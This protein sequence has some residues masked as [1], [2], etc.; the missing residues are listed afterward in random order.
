MVDLAFAMAIICNICI[1]LRFLER[2]VWLSVVLSLITAAIQDML[3]I[4]TITPFL[5][6]FPRSEGYVYLQGFWAMAASMIFSVTA[7][8]LMFIDLVFTSH[9]RLR[10]SGVTRKQRILITE[11]MGMCLYLALGAL[12]FIYIEGW[13]YLDAL[14]FVF[15]TVTTIGFGD[16]VPTTAGG[17]VF[18]VFYAAGGI[19]FLGVIISSMRY[20]ILEAVERGFNNR[21][22]KRKAKRQARRMELRVQQAREAEDLRLKQ[23]NER[24]CRIQASDTDQ[25]LCSGEESLHGTRH[26]DSTLPHV[27]G[28]TFVGMQRTA[29]NPQESALISTSSPPMQG[30]NTTITF[31]DQEPPNRPDGGF[32]PWDAIDSNNSH[33]ETEKNHAVAS[34]PNDKSW[35]RR[36]IPFL[37][38]KPT[39]AELVANMHRAT[40]EELQKAEKRQAH[41]ET[42]REYRVRLLLSAV[43]FVAYWLIGGIVFSFLETWDFGTAIY[44][45][46][47]TFTT[48]GYGDLIPL[49][50]AGR[51]IFLVYGLFGI[52][53]L[54]S[55][56]SLIGEDLDKRVK[57]HE[58]DTQLTRNDLDLE[59]G[60][61]Q[62]AKGGDS[63]RNDRTQM[64]HSLVEASPDIDAGMATHNGDCE[65]CLQKLVNIANEF[66][67]LLQKVIAQN[68]SQIGNNKTSHPSMTL[69]EPPSHGIVPSPS[70]SPPPT[71]RS[72]SSPSYP[73]TRQHNRD[74]VIVVPAIQW[75]QLIDYATQFRA[76]T[77][78][79]E[80]AQQKVAAWDARERKLREKRHKDR[81]R[82]KKLLQKRRKQLEEQ[83]S[84]LESDS[85]NEKEELEDLKDWDEEGS[86]NDDDDEALDQSRG[87]IAEML[88]GKKKGDVRRSSGQCQRG[89]RRPSSVHHHHSFEQQSQHP[90]DGLDDESDQNRSMSTQPTRLRRS[91]SPRS[92]IESANHARADYHY[93][94]DS[95]GTDASVQQQRQQ[96]QIDNLRQTRPQSLHRGAGAGL[97]PPLARTAGAD[98]TDE[99]PISVSTQSLTQSRLLTADVIAHAEPDSN[100]SEHRGAGALELES[101]HFPAP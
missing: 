35:W 16:K 10:G 78:A 96:E 15:I 42:M 99:P 85:M 53:A 58:V 19:V 20:V 30:E 61:S 77:E 52:V 75:R 7:T 47:I 12:V 32:Q 57:E 36:S 51:A 72:S 22:K 6:L 97:S 84:G 92:S 82:Q 46:F 98:L 74:D 66:D 87:R 13:A 62:E 41:K 76:L 89:D 34:H 56:A 59:T 26:S 38:K 100:V 101:R 48:I 68:S 23:E 37:Q 11:A 86:N 39:T 60:L 50:V 40:A 45:C 2:H 29:D 18:V 73:M 69:S 49:S 90:S 25:C 65:G 44:F 24:L 8:V 17:R 55:L 43:M 63:Q 33:N 31:L 91:L 88:L 4:A 21:A 28:T 79:C 5:I 81:L 83:G 9:F 54:T 93:G 71:M 80:D 67:Q 14:F 3:C 1:L 64:L 27:S 94:V 95:S 70:L